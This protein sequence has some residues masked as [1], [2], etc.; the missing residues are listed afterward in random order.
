MTIIECLDHPDPIVKREVSE[1][2]NLKIQLIFKMGER[3]SKRGCVKGMFCLGYC[4]SRYKQCDKLC[5]QA[6]YFI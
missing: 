3:F 2:L 5:R 1:F 6:V 4:E